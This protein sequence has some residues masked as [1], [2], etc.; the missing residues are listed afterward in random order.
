MCVKDISTSHPKR[1]LGLVIYAKTSPPVIEF[2]CEACGCPV[3]QREGE[4]HIKG[5]QICFS[6]ELVRA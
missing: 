6:C 2:C 5:E 4:P 1:K 3:F